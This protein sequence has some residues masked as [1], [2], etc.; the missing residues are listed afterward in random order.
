MPR[1]LLAE[2]D[3]MISRM[4]ELRLSI[5][6]YQV[7]PASNGQIAVKMALDAEYDLLLMDMHMPVL[8]GHQ[9][10]K[11]LREAGYQGLIIAVTASALSQDC[12]KA[13]NS[14][15]DYHIPKPIGPEFE[16]Q[17]SDIL[18]R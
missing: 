4:L 16:Q 3:E 8:D 1:I 5:A 15:C 17:L 7:D 10:T 13:I 6:G 9:A 18:N 2:D 11:Q 14:G 12:E